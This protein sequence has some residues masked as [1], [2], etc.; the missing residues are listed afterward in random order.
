[1]VKYIT[2]ASKIIKKTFNVVNKVSKAPKAKKASKTIKAKIP[3]PR[4]NIL[5]YNILSGI[6]SLD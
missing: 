5:I 4:E 2:P 6:I 1:M 3:S